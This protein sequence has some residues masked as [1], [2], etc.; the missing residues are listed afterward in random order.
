MTEQN[1]EKAEP[2]QDDTDAATALW[3]SI[4]FL[5][6]DEACIEAVATW[7]ASRVAAAKA[8]A[9]KGL[10]SAAVDHGASARFLNQLNELLSLVEASSLPSAEPVPC[11]G[12]GHCPAPLH[13]HGCYADLDG[14]TCDDPSDHATSSTSVSEEET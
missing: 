3:E 11:D 7:H 14:S 5:M 2:T 13:V 8:G 9:L 10:F 4:E 12:S 6:T 1:V